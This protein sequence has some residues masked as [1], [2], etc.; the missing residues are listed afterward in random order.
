MPPK[1]R[2]KVAPAAAPTET[3]SAPSKA[4]S[5]ANKEVKKRALDLS[6]AED[7]PGKK[8]LMF[9]DA[10]CSEADYRHT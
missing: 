5:L 10:T 7:A 1:A 6:D 9:I 8:V 4:P 2:K 3:S